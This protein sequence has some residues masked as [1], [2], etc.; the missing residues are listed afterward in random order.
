VK[1][2]R[3][4]TAA[5]SAG[6]VAST[7]VMATGAQ[8]VTATV[9]ANC[10]YFTTYGT[11]AY[12][13]N[14]TVSGNLTANGLGYMKYN[15]QLEYLRNSWSWSASVALVPNPTYYPDGGGCRPE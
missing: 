15:G 10:T 8:A 3:L 11:N 14:C 12:D 4:R 2:S 9:T 13:S 6:A 5:L 1:Y 7:L